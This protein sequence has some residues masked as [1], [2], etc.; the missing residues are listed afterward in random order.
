MKPILGYS[1]RGN[2]DFEDCPPQLTGIFNRFA[3]QMESQMLSNV[4]RAEKIEKVKISENGQN[5]R[6]LETAQWG[7]GYPFNM[8]AQE[9]DGEKCPSGCLATAMAI[10]MKY[11]NWPESGRG[12]HIWISNGS[13]LDYDFSQTSFDYSLMADSYEPGT[14]D[15]QQAKE[16]AKL[17]QAA[18]AAVNMQ[19]NPEGSGAMTCVSGHYMHEYFKYSPSCQ[20]LSASNFNESKW[21][22]MIFDQIDSNHPIIMS[23]VS[24]E[25]GG[26]AFICDGY[27]DNNMLHIN[28]GWNGARNGYFD[29]VLLG[30]F[31]NNIGMVINLFNDG[32]EKGYARC[33]NDFGYLWAD[34]GVGS[35]F[36]VSVESI[37]K[38]VPF[39]ALVGRINFPN[40][41]SGTVCLALVD[42]SENIIE[43][44]E[45]VGHRFECNTD[46]DHI[47]YSWVGHGALPFV[48][49]SFKTE[50]GPS[51]KVQVVARE[52][53]EE[54]KLVLGTLEAPSYVRVDGNIPLYSKIEWKIKDPYG[55]TK[56]I[57]Q[58]NN[59]HYVLLG[60]TC[61]FNIDISGGVTY[62]F[63]DGVFRTN[64][65]DFSKADFN[66]NTTKDNYL[67]E[68]FANRYEDLLHKNVTLDKAGHLSELIPE[69]EQ[70][71]IYSLTIEGPMNSED[72]AFISRK[73]YSLKNLDV[74]ATTVEE[75]LNRADYLP[76]QAGQPGVTDAIGAAVWG[77]ESIKLP[78]TLKG[79]EAFSMPHR[80]I[81]CLEI[82][83]TVEDYEWN[84]VSGYSGPKI[85]F[86][87]VN[88]PKPV[89]I[90][91]GSGALDLVDDGINRN[92]TV[93][94]VPQG[95]KE[96]YMNSPSWRGYKDIRESDKDFSGK[97]VEY[98][99]V[100]YLIIAETAIA[101]NI[102]ADS[103]YRY[104]YFVVPEYIEFEGRNYPV[105]GN[106]REFKT[107]CLYLDNVANFDFNLLDSNIG[108]AVTPYIDADYT[109]G[110]PSD[111]MSLMI[112]GAT[113]KHYVKSGCNI[114]EMWTY[115][116]DKE[117]KLL[118][119][120][121]Q[122]D[123]CDIPEIIIDGKIAVP[124]KDNLYSFTDADNLTVDIKF[125]TFG[126]EHYMKTHYSPEYHID[127]PS[128]DLSVPVESIFLSV[129]E[130]GIHE[131][132][133]INI[134]A[135]VLPEA[136]T[137]K[138]VI[139]SSDDESIARVDQ[140]GKVSAVN[141]GE[142]NIIAMAADGSGVSAVC[143]ITVLPILVETILLNPESW[144]GVEGESF[145]IEVAVYPENATFKD[146]VWTS[147]DEAVAIVDGEGIVSVLK[148]GVCV[149]SVSALDGS[150]VSAE[151]LITSVA[152][153]NEI[154]DE[155]KPC[156]VY[157]LNGILI[158]KN[159]DNE[160]LKSLMPDVYIIR[161]D[162]KNIK[163]I[164][165]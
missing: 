8:Y 146:L 119:V 46:L 24:E 152:G 75:G 129:I 45:Q 47:G 14:F 138:S 159:C 117:H 21:L 157:T 22:N 106:C 84:S 85:D 48:N 92:R 80:S 17:M 160:F 56:L 73:L 67:I 63:I 90:L 35:G 131:R 30:G 142:C 25:S 158:R 69:E 27:D 2:F 82:P 127:L 100:R 102:Y 137:N 3:S 115:L 43:V 136:A 7:Q 89:E 121:P 149:I 15:D 64:G 52:D 155:G 54:W 50:V 44:N 20:Y 105:S 57:Y 58:N 132:E 153:V 125:S 41:F 29:P 5:G 128:I 151:C 81:E 12:H 55:L 116:I 38:E 79:F 23:G 28:W 49:L 77:L 83:G 1:V 150:G 165:R 120:I 39:N 113:S 36:N 71:L 122:D 4:C 31:N 86:L 108:T 112:P 156:D 101:S 11:N 154:F 143:H 88:N 19:Y 68:I 70:P 33:W 126:N 61:P 161:Q 111:Y 10:V 72:Y 60:D 6:V 9:Q 144:N 40:D 124:V 34:P 53:G 96:A 110:N 134:E 135:H 164:I 162:S 26:H 103:P 42:E 130:L 97:F 114:R 76:E 107:M 91:D 13:Q 65:S 99:G 94:Y 139:W 62:V 104:G 123:I 148:E 109:G 98:D 147:S 93:L 78:D 118:S 37:E 87:K 163:V 74:H 95:S 66:F 141:I 51:M 16:V 133:S 145:R 32:C 18:G 59:E 140:D